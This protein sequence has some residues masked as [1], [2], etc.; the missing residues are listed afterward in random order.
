MFFQHL[1]LQL[2]NLLEFNNS[3]SKM[4]CLFIIGRFVNP[5]M[6][7]AKIQPSTKYLVFT[8]KTV[9]LSNYIF[10]TTTILLDILLEKQKNM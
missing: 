4:V 2:K 7:F 1:L 5:F 3:S 10:K 9:H 6:S 8:N